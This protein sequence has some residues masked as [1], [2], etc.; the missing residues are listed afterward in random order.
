[1]TAARDEPWHRCT[2]R[3][4]I[5]GILRELFLWD[6]PIT[7]SLGAASHKGRID[8]LDEPED[9]SATSSRII[10]LRHEVTI[11]PGSVVLSAQ[12][13]EDE[14]RWDAGLS[15]DE[16]LT[17]T[18]F[19]LGVEMRK[20]KKH[21]RA[22]PGDAVVSVFCRSGAIT[23]P[24]IRAE[25][26]AIR[27]YARSWLRAWPMSLV[28]HRLERDADGR[29]VGHLCAVRMSDGLVMVTDVARTRLP[30]GTDAGPFMRD[31]IGG[32][33]EFAGA[34]DP[35]VRIMIGWAP[36]HP[37]WA[38]FDGFISHAGSPFP[39]VAFSTLY[40]RFAEPTDIS[41]GSNALSLLSAK[42]AREL[43]EHLP[44]VGAKHLAE[45]LGVGEPFANSR[46][47]K[48]L[49]L[50]S[51]PFERAAVLVRR[52]N[53]SIALALFPGLP[54]T[55][56][57]RKTCSC[58]WLF[59]FNNWSADDRLDVYRTLRASNWVGG[60][61]GVLEVTAVNGDPGAGKWLDWRIVEPAALSAFDGWAA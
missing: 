22:E 12:F 13:G 40:T 43:I 53:R 4:Q 26:A 55:W 21:V 16:H 48:E 14:I 32:V 25:R 23:A 3:K 38:G 50:A 35:P 33:V 11:A 34:I 9:S 18:P 27:T 58:V 61:P 49:A 5:H 44:Q 57:L 7:V 52:E 41:G 17:T 54:S 30:N 20:V 29:V 51:E 60:A 46:L 6:A 1:M 47:A 45:A 36:G 42:D 10:R 24:F 8:D 39:T 28:T 59:P 2:D 31:A 37:L 15:V 56:N 19:P